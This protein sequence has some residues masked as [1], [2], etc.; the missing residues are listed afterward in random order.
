MTEKSH[1]SMGFVVC[2]VC[3]CEHSETVLL[4]KRLRDVL[5]PRTFTG[6]SLC[7]EHQKLKD[8]GYIALVEVDSPDVKNSLRTGQVAHIRASV[9]PEIFNAPVPPEAICHVGED[10]MLHL[11]GLKPREED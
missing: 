7:P 9:W 8:D 1:V 5:D 6:Y 10:V 11:E 4:D 2:P 3:G